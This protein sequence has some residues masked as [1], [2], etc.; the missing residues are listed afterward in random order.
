VVA[1]AG[2]RS[3]AKTRCGGVF[4]PLLGA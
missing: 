4:D 1:T 3:G 2:A